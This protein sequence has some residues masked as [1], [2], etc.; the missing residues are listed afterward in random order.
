MYTEQAPGAL[1]PFFSKCKTNL[2]L[3][4]KDSTG[5]LVIDDLGM[6]LLF[7]RGVYIL[8]AKVDSQTIF[9]AYCAKVPT[10]DHS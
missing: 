9:Q 10:M 5:V 3:L 8:P 1:P 6:E 4:E 2:N 7:T